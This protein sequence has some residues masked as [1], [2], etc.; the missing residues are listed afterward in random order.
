M[1]TKDSLGNP[2]E[3]L[4]AEGHSHGYNPK[5]VAVP[6]GHSLH[7]LLE[8][9]GWSRAAMPRMQH[10]LSSPEQLVMGHRAL[11]FNFNLFISM[12]IFILKF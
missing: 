4:E 6:F 1:G 10:G 2:H 9:R 12:H 7:S 8:W 11:F 3:V 5:Q